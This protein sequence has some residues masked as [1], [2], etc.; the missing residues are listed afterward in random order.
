MNALTHW[1]QKNSDLVEREVNQAIWNALENSIFPGAQRGSIIMAVDYCRARNLDILQKPVHI[2]RMQV[3]APNSQD[4][5]WRDV[6]MPGIGLYRIQAN[7]SKDFAGIDEPEFGPD[8]TETF[9]IPAKEDRNGNKQGQDREITLT[10]PVWC[11]LTVYKMV[12]GQRCAFTVR[13]YWKE[14]Y[15][16]VGAWSE[17]PNAMWSKRPH[18]QLAK[19]AEA[20]A[21]R[22][23]WPEIDAGPTAEEMEGKVIELDERDI[24][25]AADD[26]KAK[27]PQPLETKQQPIEGE[28]VAAG[29]QDPKGKPNRRKKAEAAPEPEQNDDEGARLSPQQIKLIRAR[30][31]INQVS[32][33]ELLLHFKADCFESLPAKRVN[34]ILDYANKKAT[35]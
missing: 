18:G 9:V 33:E 6:V 30:T 2:V 31:A 10:Y 24:T 12:Q 14:N 15:A 27:G 1:E 20:Q 19:C 34:E 11:K 26:R 35:A 32:N 23:A 22:K 7:R 5:V 29:D 4:K 8:V 17:A 13:E 28:Y 3:K 25:P 21:L 16:T